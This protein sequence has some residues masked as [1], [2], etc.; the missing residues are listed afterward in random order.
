LLTEWAGVLV[1]SVGGGVG[2][3]TAI[4]TVRFIYGWS[5]KPL[6]YMT[7]TPVLLGSIWFATQPELAKVLGLAFN[8]GAVTTVTVPLVLSLGIGIAHA[9]GKG[10]DSLSGFGT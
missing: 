7:L 10:S 2:L 6:I 3:A 5:L 1:L 9:A 4:G 8:C